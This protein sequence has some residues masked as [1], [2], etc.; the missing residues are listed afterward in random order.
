MWF[1]FDRNGDPKWSSSAVDFQSTESLTQP[2]GPGKQIDNCY[3][4]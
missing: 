3:W 4:I 1:L 2:S